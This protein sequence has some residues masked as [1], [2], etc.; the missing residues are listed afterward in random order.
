MW[1]L[2]SALAV[3]LAL[4]WLYHYCGLS[5][6]THGTIHLN[7]IEATAPHLTPCHT[8]SEST[9]A[10]WQDVLM[11]RTVSNMP[12][13]EADRRRQKALRKAHKWRDKQRARQGSKTI[14]SSRQTRS[15]YAHP[16]PLIWT[17]YP[18]STC[19]ANVVGHLNSP[20]QPVAAASAHSRPTRA[21]T[22]ASARGRRQRHQPSEQLQ[23]PRNPKKLSLS[24]PSPAAA[25]R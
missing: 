17:L 24:F 15:A 18:P 13:A 3:D 12:A 7:H 10:D 20:Y 9:P 19:T 21:L 22:I 16:G 25:P 4:G 8:P 1:E 11:G 23:S 2:A 5:V 6:C 14:A